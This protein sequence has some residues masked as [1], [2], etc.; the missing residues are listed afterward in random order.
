MESEWYQGIS[1]EDVLALVAYMRTMPPVNNEVPPSKLS[2]IAKTMVALGI[3]KAQPPI[4]TPIIAPS[5][6]TTAK[7][8]KYLASSTSMCAGCHTPRSPNTGKYDMTQSFAGGLFPLLE[9]GFSTTGS[10]LTPDV[11]TG[12][13]NWTEAQFMTAMRT[14][15]RPDGTVMLPFMP[16]PVYDRW[17]EGDLR[18]VWLYLQS[19]EPIVHEVPVSTLTDAAV[20]G[21]GTARGQAV[22]NV[23]CVI[24]HGD[25]GAGSLLATNSLEDAG[26]RM[27]DTTLTKLIAE[28]L[29]GIS[30]PG[31]D[32]TLTA[33]QIAD[34]VAYISNW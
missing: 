19:L 30:M 24:C 3:L 10:N 27:D 26:S 9:E 21:K 22:Y 11:A 12:I 20:T 15:V 16:W 33:E 8:G 18:A 2:F 7:Y 32:R 4:T 13:G 1:D 28:G 29:P 23:F 14:G 31:F 6:A 25:K 34:L 5:Q 17:S